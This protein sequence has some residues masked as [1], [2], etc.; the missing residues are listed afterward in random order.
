MIPMGSL[1]DLSPG[2][3][4]VAKEG[5]AT[6]EVEIKGDTLIITATC[7][8]L[9]QLVYR[10]EKELAYKADLVE[11]LQKESKSVG[12]NFNSFAVGVLVGVVILII[13]YK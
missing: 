6:A 12:F 13:K 1:H 11:N 8:S 3:K 9:Q 10:Y 7:D 4:F 5:R 2:A